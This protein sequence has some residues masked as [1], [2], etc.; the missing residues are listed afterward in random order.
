MELVD[1]I[2]TL[3]VGL[4]VFSQAIKWLIEQIKDQG[5]IAS[6]LPRR[7]ADGM[8]SAGEAALDDE[9][10]SAEAV[11]V[12]ALMAG[13]SPVAAPAVSA[14]RAAPAAAAASAPPSAAAQRG[15]RLRRQLGLDERGALQRSVLLMTILGPCRAN[16]R[17][18]HHG[19]F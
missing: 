1:F 16:E 12:A 14:M 18:E 15:Q 17:G 19:P 11:A 13:G 5:T 7:R 2:V 10:Q 8:S 9:A 4:A 6:P 3:L